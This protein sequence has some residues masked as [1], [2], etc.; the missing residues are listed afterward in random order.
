MILFMDRGLGVGQ[1]AVCTIVYLSVTME[2]AGLTGLI[3]SWLTLFL[4]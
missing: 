2:T 4:L 3:F 1:S